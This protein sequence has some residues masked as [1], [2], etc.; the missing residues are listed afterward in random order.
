MSAR[1]CGGYGREVNSVGG[2]LG[3]SR[4]R[5]RGR[6]RSCLNRRGSC[7]ALV[8]HETTGAVRGYLQHEV[9]CVS[10]V[11]H[12][13][14]DWCGVLLSEPLEVVQHR[15]LR[16][17]ACLGDDWPLVDLGQTIVGDVHLKTGDDCCPHGCSCQAANSTRTTAVTGETPGSAP[18]GGDFSAAGSMG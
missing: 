5:S 14:S 10:T 12:R 11:V 7:I 17:L 3:R 8:V 15:L 4:G 1:Y 2:D 9:D 13:G 18:R 6:G 16:G